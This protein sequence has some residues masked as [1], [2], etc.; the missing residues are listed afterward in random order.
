MSEITYSEFCNLHNLVDNEKSKEQYR[1]YQAKLKAFGGVVPN[2]TGHGGARDGSGRKP[3]KTGKTKVMRIPA[4]YEI[5]VK[6]LIEHL[7]SEDVADKST[8]LSMKDV[9]GESISLKIVTKL[10]NQ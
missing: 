4:I 6:A 10:I 8:E 1:A 3:S 7:T 5:Q 2:K 9:D